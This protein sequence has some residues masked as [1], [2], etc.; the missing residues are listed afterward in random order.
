MTPVIVE[1]GPHTVRGPGSAPQLW[2]STAIDTIDDR[3]ALLDE[4]PVDVSALWQD[5]LGAVAG[6]RADPLVLVIPT[7]WSQ[8]RVD[9]VGDA[10]DTVATNVVVLQR[11]TTLADGADATVVELSADYAVVTAPGSES[12]VFSRGTTA[13]TEYLETATA[14][15]LD[16]PAGVPPLPATATAGLRRLGI[17]VTHSTDDRL[18]RAATAVA[19]RLAAREGFSVRRIRPSRRVT[20]VLA[21]TALTVAAACGGWAVQAMEARPPADAATRL[22]VDGR[23]AVRVPASWTVER[24]TSGSGSARVRV[25]AP[26]GAPALHITQSAGPAATTIAD[27]AESLRRA[28]DTEPVGVF[29]DFDPSGER[30]GRPA[31]TYVEK[32]AAGETRWAVL[33]DGSVRIAIG[34]QAAPGDPAAVEDACLQAVRSAHV[35]R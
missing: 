15:L 27:V 11:S 30:G 35:V 18:R 19:L 8:G 28:I 5:V 17:P 32:R 33:V 31:V 7:W 20:A 16:V 9:V 12:L 10:A 23:I 24:I 6:E 26:G 1:A 13:F 4:Q 25:S 34:C 21:G 2:I 29:V 3:I 14:V 22:L